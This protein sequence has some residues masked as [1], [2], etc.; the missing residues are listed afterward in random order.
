M[1][2]LTKV[3]MF[4]SRVNQPSRLFLN[5]NDDVSNPR[6]FGFNSF[7]INLQT[8]V[9]NPTKLQLLRA[10][11][12]N[13]LQN[14]PNYQLQFW[15]YRLPSSTSVPSDGFLRCV[16]LYPSDYVA[17]SG[18]TSFVRNRYVTD[19]TDLVTLLNAAASTGGDSG[20]YNPYWAVNDVTFTYNSSSKLI[21][22]TGNTA[23]L[24]YC[25]A[26]YN[27]PLVLAAQRGN[28]GQGIITLNSFNGSDLIQPSVPQ[29]TLNLRVGFAMSGQS[30][31][32][33][34]STGNP[35][36]ANITNTAVANGVAIVA[37]SYPNL[38]YTGSV[39]LYSDI[40]AGSSMGSN[41]EHNLL[42]VIPNNVPQLGIINYVA[43]TLT[44][45]NRIPDT[46][47][48]IIVRTCFMVWYSSIGC[49]ATSDE[50][51]NRFNLFNAYNRIFTSFNY[52]NWCNFCRYY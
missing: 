20:T 34:S 33:Q 44:W 39:Y 30:L 12:P 25:I 52:I 22:M 26:G 6:S 21:S 4:K 47:Y 41:N 49:Y 40:V 2:S 38:V 50:Y 17:P 13:A 11:I 24:F 15:Y 19:P 51:N 29:F 16:R 28:G 7:S 48:Q 9:L 14:I 43:A 27:D 31:A 37:D 45:L 8:P 10:T 42:A 35:Q 1:L 36:Y 5:S 18:F 46:I 23:G 32:P 3:E